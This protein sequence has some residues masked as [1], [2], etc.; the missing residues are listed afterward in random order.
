[1]TRL[2]NPA[3]VHAP[4]ARACSQPH[5]QGIGA[6]MPEELPRRK[7]S[8]GMV[9]MLGPV[10]NTA[11]LHPSDFLG[12]RRILPP[13]APGYGSHEARLNSGVQEYLAHKKQRRP[14][15]LQQ[16]YA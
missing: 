11:L 12:G 14:R 16:G 2:V 8:S 9:T 5:V 10:F 4:Q 7:N 13:P 3:C 1:M 6:T 15:T